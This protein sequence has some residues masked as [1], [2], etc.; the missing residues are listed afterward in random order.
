MTPNRDKLMRGFLQRINPAWLGVVALVFGLLGFAVLL[1]SEQVV[2]SELYD[3]RETQTDNSTWVVVQ[4]EIDYQNLRWALRDAAEYPKGAVPEDIAETAMRYFDIF[5][6]RV[7]NSEARLAQIDEMAVLPERINEPRKRILAVRDEMADIIDAAP[8]PTSIDFANLLA[9]LEELH[10][11]PRVVSVDAQQ[12]IVKLSS[13]RFERQMSLQRYFLIISVMMV[14]VIFIVCGISLVMARDLSRKNTQISRISS[15]LQRTFDASHDAIIVSNAKGDITF[16]SLAAEKLFGTPDSTLVGKRMQDVVIPKRFLPTFQDEMRC[17]TSHRRGK[18]VDQGCIR[19][20]CRSPHVGLFSAEITAVSDTDSNNQPVIIAFVRDVSA[21][22][23]VERLQRLARLEAEQLARSKEQFI[24]VVSHE[25]RTPI[26]G[27]IASLDL[28]TDHEMSPAVK[29]LISVAQ[30]SADITRDLVEEVLEAAHLQSDTPT[31]P[32]EAFDPKAVVMGIA[33]LMESVAHPKN[34]D[35]VLDKGDWPSGKILGRQ[36]AFRY[37][38]RNLVSNAVK[39]TSNGTITIRLKSG[40]THPDWMRVEVEDTGPG[41]SPADHGRIF[42]DFESIDQTPGAN[43]T[44]TG[45]GLGIVRRSVNSLGG[46]L[47]LESELGKGAMFWFEIPAIFST[48]E[49][50][51]SPDPSRSTAPKRVEKAEPGSAGK[52]IIIDDNSTNRFVVEKM[53][54]RLGY[55]VVSFASGKPAVLRSRDTKFD[56]ILTDINMPGMSGYEVL[57]S[58]RDGGASAQAMVVAVTAQ[59]T[60]GVSELDDGLQFDGVLS[61]PM[62]HDDLADMLSARRDEQSTSKGDDT[63]E[64]E[65]DLLLN[66]QTIDELVEMLGTEHTQKIITRAFDDAEA[67]L[68]RVLEGKAEACEDVADRVHHALGSLGFIGADRLNEALR[69]LENLLRQTDSGDIAARVD[70]ISDTMSAT[71]QR[72][73]ENYPELWSEAQAV[74]E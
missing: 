52:A 70:A 43:I 61:K 30:R 54:E 48:K 13:D 74:A 56:V 49:E 33:Q 58:I 29:S 41:I 53:M 27:I 44:G 40:T 26:H 15:M 62:T 35:I 51:D 14:A 24:A 19:T 23:K 10:G 67:A 2:E 65:S 20:V 32:T 73:R 12:S 9:R 55:E 50:E 8:D 6:G 64:G 39:F 71:K 72:Y 47:G 45:L 63:T 28:L 11:L 60:A 42:N 7:T 46:E 59:G 17:L 22:T 69:E 18:I 5:Y 38:L 31:D 25:L 34:T 36:R 66:P 37:A 16:S 57:R 3:L 1:W 21:R 68:T 4:L